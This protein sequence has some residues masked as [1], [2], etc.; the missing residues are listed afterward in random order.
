MVN[1]TER[2][3]SIVGIDA[4]G[5]QRAIENIKQRILKD[6]SRPLNTIIFYSKEIKLKDLQEKILTY[7]FDRD[8]LIIFKNTCRLSADV[9]KFL[10]KSFE[11]IASLN[12][13]VF[14]IER[15]SFSLAR[16]SKISADKFFQ[17]ILKKGKVLKIVSYGRKLTVD[18]FK[19]SFRSNN[20]ASS[21]YALEKLFDEAGKT[22]EKEYGTFILGV[23]LAEVSYRRTPPQKERSL[24]LFWE[25]DRGL[26]ERGLD[27]R[28]ALEVLVTKLLVT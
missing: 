4:L 8:K 25:T 14:E 15:D 11:K 3:F 20:L 19:R 22:K 23:L 13:L 27:S 18:D 24:N 21:L 7:S 17:F 6:K 26:K 12:Y 5:R 1:I 9:K 2:V 16:D 28:L 10:L